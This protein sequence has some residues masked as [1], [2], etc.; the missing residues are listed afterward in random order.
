MMKVSYCEFDIY[1]LLNKIVLA[2]LQYS[3]SQRSLS[4]NETSLIRS[5]DDMAN[6]VEEMSAFSR[7]ELLKAVFSKHNSVSNMTKSG[8]IPVRLMT[9]SIFLEKTADILD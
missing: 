3:W 2:G 5:E 6:L 9:M 8:F 7:P 4:L 1:V